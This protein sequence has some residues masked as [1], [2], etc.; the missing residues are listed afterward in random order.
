MK[1]ELTFLRERIFFLNSQPALIDWTTAD[2][3]LS[4]SVPYI[5]LRLAMK[6]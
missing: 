2:R 1:V 3:V 6:C 5:T 4:L